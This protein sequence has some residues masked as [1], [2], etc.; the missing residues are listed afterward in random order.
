MSSGDMLADRRFDFARDLQLERRPGGR[1]RP[2]CRR[3]PTLRPALRPPGSRSAKSANCW[4]TATGAIAAFR[5]AETTDPGDRN[6]AGLRLMHWARPISPPCG[7]LTSTCFVRSVC[8]AVRMPRWWDDLGY[9]GPALLLGRGA[10]R[11]RSGGRVRFSIHARLSISAAAQVWP[12]ARSRPVADKFIGIDLSP[13]MIER[14]RATGLY[15]ELEV[16]EIAVRS[17]PPV[18]CQRRPGSS[19]P[20]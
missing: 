20:T 7:Q 10:R 8:A 12:H 9:R 6:G 1:G 2:V 16:A 19:P 5:A 18:G 4:E 15:A 3:R 13:R 17:P 14:A 11:A